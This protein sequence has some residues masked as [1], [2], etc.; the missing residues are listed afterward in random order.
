MKQIWI[1]QDPPVTITD[2]KD[3]NTAWCTKAAPRSA[4]RPKKQ[5]Y[6]VQVVEVCEVELGGVGSAASAE[7]GRVLRA[8]NIMQRH[9]VLHSSTLGGDK[10]SHVYRTVVPTQ[11][12]QSKTK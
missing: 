8:G 7:S 5:T 6:L 10:T 11:F 12:E 1:K 3:N 2:N 9:L 4:V